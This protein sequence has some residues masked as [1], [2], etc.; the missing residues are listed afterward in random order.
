MP[1]GPGRL[2]PLAKPGF[3]ATVLPRSNIIIRCLPAALLLTAC[4]LAGC[5]P[6]PLSMAEV[7]P[8]P[9]P[10]GPPDAARIQASIDRGVAYLIE[11]Q[12]SD[13]HWGTMLNPTYG[14]GLPS[15]RDV[16]SLK[17]ATTCL[18]LKALIE[19]N[20]G[21]DKAE[22]AIRRAEDWA[23][24]N[25]PKFRRQDK[26]SLFNNWGHAYAIEA[27]VAMLKYRPMDEARH[28]RVMEAL[29]DQVRLLQ[30]YQTI[31]G[32]WGYYT[33]GAPIRPPVDMGVSFLTATAMISLHQAR[34][35]GFE[36]QPR[37]VVGAMKALRLCRFPNGAFGYNI[38]RSPHPEYRSGW[39]PAAVSRTQPGNLAMYLFDDD[40]VTVRAMET[41]LARMIVQDDWLEQ[42]RKGTV[43]H[44]SNVARVTKRHSPFQIAGYYYFYG[45]YYGAQII[46]HLP[47]DKQDFYRA[48]VAE[49]IMSKQDQDGCWWDFALFQYYKEYGTAYALMILKRCLP[50]PAAVPEG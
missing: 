45:Y 47:E 13:G 16:E 14:V 35:M 44:S 43:P 39:P 22:A 27:L 41:W 36:L 12:K 1:I 49:I 15:Y 40:R 9:G 3:G 4:W 11:H 46:E 23:L 5:E 17:T 19:N 10:I 28:A 6:A 21:T 20:P 30:A 26:R 48:H 33:G 50:E 8:E 2:H 31:H 29:A 34:E 32:S 37:T 38:Y 24:E 7:G 42:T 18:A 25:L